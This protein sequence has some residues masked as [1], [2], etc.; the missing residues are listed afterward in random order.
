MVS[1]MLESAGLTHA[2]ISVWLFPPSESGAGGAGC[3]RHCSVVD[4]SIRLFKSS[5]HLPHGNHTI[6]TATTS[7]TRQ[8][9]PP[10]GNQTIDTATKPS[11]RQPNHPPGNQTIHPVTKPSTHQPNHPPGNQTIHTATTPSTRQPHH[12]HGSLRLVNVLIRAFFKE[13]LEINSA[14]KVLFSRKD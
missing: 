4:G 11:T 5:H 6:H 7:S 3:Y 12:P 13:S 2:I 8:P 1:S 10:H 14:S 9:N